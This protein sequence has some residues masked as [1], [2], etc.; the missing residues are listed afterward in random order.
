MRSYTQSSYG[1]TW[2]VDI[3]F[4][5]DE[6]LT[7]SMCRSDRNAI[8]TDQSKPAQHDSELTL[9]IHYWGKLYL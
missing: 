5:M 9:T 6:S 7:E 4:I 1:K 3:S 2:Q 8:S